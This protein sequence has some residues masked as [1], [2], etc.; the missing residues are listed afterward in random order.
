MPRVLKTIGWFFN[1]LCQGGFAIRANDHGE[2][3]WLSRL[4][5]S[6]ENIENNRGKIEYL[7]P[8]IS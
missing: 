6:I 2:S 1:D 4:C 5:G 8:N 7:G 3:W